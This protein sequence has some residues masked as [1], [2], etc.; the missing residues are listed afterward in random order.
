MSGLDRVAC[1]GC[2]R[3]FSTIDG[4]A[5]LASIKGDCPDCGGSFSLMEDQAS[6]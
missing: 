4:V 2:G 6:C 1:D 5:M 3:W